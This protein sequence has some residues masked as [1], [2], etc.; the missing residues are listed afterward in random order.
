MADPKTEKIEK[1]LEES[2]APKLD[3]ELSETEFEQV[4][5]GV[6]VTCAT[7]CPQSEKI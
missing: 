7:T 6:V 4:S 1:K 3:N 2:G 5:G